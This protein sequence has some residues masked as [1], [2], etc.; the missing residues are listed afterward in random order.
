[1]NVESSGPINELFP[2]FNSIE[3]IRV[4]ETN[5]NAEFS[6]VSDVTTTSKSGTNAYH[7]GIFENHENAPLNAGNPFSTSKPKLVMNN[8]GGFVVDPSLFEAL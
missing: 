8:F 4:S 6:G 3:E 1:V 5:N 7:G 2:S